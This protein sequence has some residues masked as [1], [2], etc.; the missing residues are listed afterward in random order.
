[1]DQCLGF[2]DRIIIFFIKCPPSALNEILNFL[3]FFLLRALFLNDDT[4]ALFQSFKWFNSVELN[5]E[6]IKNFA[7]KV[8]F[9]LF[10]FEFANTFHQFADDSLKSYL[11]FVIMYRYQN[12]F[13]FYDLFLDLS[14][15]FDN[16]RHS[17]NIIQKSKECLKFSNNFCICSVS[18]LSQTS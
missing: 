6:N 17:I 15:N 2:R 16:F 10:F 8:F 3:S 9:D 7:I 4:D 13:F 14:F 1:M 5:K 18:A 12:W 11:L